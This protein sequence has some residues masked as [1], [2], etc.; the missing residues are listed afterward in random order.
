M[1]KKPDGKVVAEIG[2]KRKRKFKSF[3]ASHGLTFKKW[4]INTINLIIE[5]EG[6][7]E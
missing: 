2:E 1:I 4:L 7:D 6:K 5:R 3:L